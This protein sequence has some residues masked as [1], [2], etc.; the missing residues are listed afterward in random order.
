LRLAIALGWHSLAYRELLDLVRH[1]ES[2]RFEAAFVDGDISQIPGRGEADLLD[3]WTVTA[4]LLASTERIQIGS[5]RLAHHW[6]AARLAQAAA[7]L[8]RI[9]PGRFRFLISIGGQPADQCFGLRF[10][11]ARE[12]IA[13]LDETL[14]AVRRLWR[15][16][17]V[18]ARGQFVRL[19]GARIRP[20]PPAGRLPIEIA[21]ARPKMLEVVATHADVWEINLPPIPS[22]VRAA[23]QQLAAACRRKHRDPAEI[24]RSMWIFTR[25]HQDPGDASLRD[26]FRRLNPWFQNLPDEQLGDAIV[27]GSPERCRRRIGEIAESLRL[28]LPVA[29]LSGLPH[30]AARRAIDALASGEALVDANTQ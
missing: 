5:I 27:A 14:W 11:S 4:A 24:L 30:N 23:E 21:A 18:T 9:A 3:G 12:R 19:S 2:A 10:P 1:A 13:W 8:E 29:D 17:E 20:C 25:P 6:N 7:T 28:D 22:R 26:E 16:E 15:G